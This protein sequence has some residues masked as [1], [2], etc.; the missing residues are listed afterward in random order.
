MKKILVILFLFA[1]ANNVLAKDKP[2]T[3]ASM[4]SAHKNDIKASLYMATLVVPVCSVVA[5]EQLPL[6]KES[7]SWLF[8][9]STKAN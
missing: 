4:I 3:L 7:A 5:L 1:F 6:K 8:Q 9:R 2:S